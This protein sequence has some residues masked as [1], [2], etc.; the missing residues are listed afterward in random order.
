MTELFQPLK[1]T[2]LSTSELIREVEHSDNALA[3]VLLSHMEAGSSS[4]AALSTALAEARTNV[5]TFLEELRVVTQEEQF[6]NIYISE[7]ITEL[8]ESYDE[9]LSSDCLTAIEE[10]L[11]AQRQQYEEALAEVWFHCML[12]TKEALA[13]KSELDSSIED[14]SAWYDLPEFWTTNADFENPFY[15]VL[16]A[17]RE[18]EK[19]RKK[20]EK[21]SRDALRI[22]QPL[23]KRRSRKS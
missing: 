14:S 8:V 10:F 17:K 6:D 12:T 18:R 9:A 1:Y 22:N 21:E 7:H 15:D 20:A 23:P 3:K 19:A 4:V 11:K 13:L 16:E 2:Q 5:E